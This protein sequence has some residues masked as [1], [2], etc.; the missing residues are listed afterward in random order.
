MFQVSVAVRRCL[1]SSDCRHPD[2]LFQYPDSFKVYPN[3]LFSIRKPSVSVACS[4]YP[5]APP[6]HP[7]IILGYLDTLRLNRPELVSS[8]SEYSF[9]HPNTSLKHLNAFFGIFGIQIPH[10]RILKISP[11]K[12]KIILFS[13]KIYHYVLILKIMIVYIKINYVLA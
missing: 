6:R 3:V 13:I 12:F 8:V 11:N 5:N 4:V 7:N 10:S 1:W 2:T 9:W